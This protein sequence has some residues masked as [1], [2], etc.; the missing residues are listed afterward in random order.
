MV[1]VETRAL[2]LQTLAYCFSAVGDL[3]KLC[4]SVKLIYI[5]FKLC[6]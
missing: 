5:I 3:T 2:I 4:G 1:F 6:K